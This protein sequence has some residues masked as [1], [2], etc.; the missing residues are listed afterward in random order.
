MV[1]RRRVSRHGVRLTARRRRGRGIAAAE[2]ARGAPAARDAHARPPRQC[3]VV[4][5]RGA[6]AR[7][8]VLAG[9]GA[10][11]AQRRR[12]RRARGHRVPQP[13]AAAAHRHGQV[14]PCHAP[15]RL[16]GRSLLLWHAPR[17]RRRARHLGA[18]CRRKV[19]DI[20][21]RDCAGPYVVV[22]FAPICERPAS[23]VPWSSPLI[24]PP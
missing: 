24:L 1:R 21:R 17:G 10:A 9:A 8:G 18:L 5:L 7:A 19:H 4:R 11:S 12:L 16:T 20:S 14:A 22:R 15:A 23:L 3:R 13:Q 6:G 2:P